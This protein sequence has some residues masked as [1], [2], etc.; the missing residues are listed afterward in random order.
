MKSW[1]GEKVLAEVILFF[2][3][4][5]AVE[6]AVNAGDKVLALERAVVNAYG[7]LA[8]NIK[9]CNVEGYT[10]TS[11][12]VTDLMQAGVDFKAFVRGAKIVAQG[13]DDDGFAWAVARISISEVIE[14][15]EKIQRQTQ[16]SGQITYDFSREKRL[17]RTK[18]VVVTAVGFGAVKGHLIDRNIQPNPEQEKYPLVAEARK[19]MSGITVDATTQEFVLALENAEVRAILQLVRQAKGLDVVKTLLTENGITGDNLEQIETR[20]F[21]KGATLAKIEAMP[22]GM[23]AVT[24]RLRYRNIVENTKEIIRDIQGK[25]CQ[26]IEIDTKTLDTV[27]EEKGFA[28]CKAAKSAGEDI[29][30]QL[31]PGEV[32]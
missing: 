26:A 4:A 25:V 31:L 11:E 29:G 24:V 10:I 13:C 14:N 6:S 7:R 23:V 5:V 19:A 12:A 28:S 8:Q 2:S 1:R 22:D 27:L 21:V 9:G 18:P 32:K 17:L 30:N 16:K 20:G 3:L 15:I